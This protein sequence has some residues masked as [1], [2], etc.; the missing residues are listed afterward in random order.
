MPVFVH[1]YTDG[2][3]FRWVEYDNQRFPVT[4]P[5]G[6]AAIHQ[7]ITT[8]T[9]SHDLTHELWRALHRK[10]H[11]TVSFRAG[12]TASKMKPVNW[13]RKQD[14]GDFVMLTASLTIPQW[15]RIITAARLTPDSLEEMGKLMREWADKHG[16]RL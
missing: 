12:A 8:F 7:P 1:T 16:I 2:R 11:E 14:W 15:R 9:L 5:G 10:P 13:P 3:D 4:D 6:F